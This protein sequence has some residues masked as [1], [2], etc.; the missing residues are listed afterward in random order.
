MGNC[1]RSTLDI[2]PDVLHQ[3]IVRG[4]RCHSKSLPTLITLDRIRQTRGGPDLLD[5]RI[6]RL[7]LKFTRPPRL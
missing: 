1:P 3:F 4:E 6:W 5:T 2:G 7:E